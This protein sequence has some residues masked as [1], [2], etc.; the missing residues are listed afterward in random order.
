MVG[1]LGTST[2]TRE[3]EERF[4]TQS[5]PDVKMNFLLPYG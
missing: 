1:E 5:D 2:L 4:L 3:G